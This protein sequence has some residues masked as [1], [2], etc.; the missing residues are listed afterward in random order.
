MEQALRKQLAARA[1]ASAMQKLVCDT[2]QDGMSCFSGFMATVEHI[3]KQA[4]NRAAIT[5]KSAVN[6]EAT[7]V[8]KAAEAD[9]KKK[10]RRLEPG[11]KVLFNGRYEGAAIRSST[12]DSPEIRGYITQINTIP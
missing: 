2:I 1:D 3:D 6:A 12:M 7:Y 4:D 8:F 11:D 10:G 5:L 9:L